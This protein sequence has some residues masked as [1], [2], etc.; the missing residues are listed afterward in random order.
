VVDSAS[1]GSDTSF[2]GTVTLSLASNPGGATL[3]GNLSMPAIHGV[4]TF[5]GLTLNAAGSGYIIEATTSGSNPTTTAPIAVTNPPV[6]LAITALPPASLVANQAFG[7]VVAVEDAAGN[8]V[9][10]YNGTVT[11]AWAGQRG[12]SPLHG[13]RTVSVVNGIA[14]FA[15]LSLAKVPKG[16]TLQ[17]Q[18]TA[19]GLASAVT[20]PIRVSLRPPKVIHP[21]R[22]RIARH[23]A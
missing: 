3:G 14:T 23:R 4:V 20:N 15:G 18:A 13:T 10:G 11:L 8:V 21:S 16:F 1:G 7:L 2:T 5:Y 9:A 17:L 19:S 22:A 12:K 6:K